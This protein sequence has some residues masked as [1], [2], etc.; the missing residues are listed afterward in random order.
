MRRFS[1]GLIAAAALIATSASPA[2]AAVTI[3]QT[4]TPTGACTSNTFFQ[5]A[6]LAQKYFA[7]SSGVITSWAFQADSSPPQPLKFKVGRPA[8]G[9]SYTVVGT[10]AGVSPTPGVLNTFET[11]IP[12]QAG[13]QIGFF[14]GTSG[15][16]AA[17]APAGNGIAFFGADLSPGDP[18]TTF[19]TQDQRLLDVSAK[20]E[21]DAD[22]DGFGDETQDKCVGSAGSFNGCPSTVSIDSAKQQGKKPR[23]TVTATVPGAGMLQ[24]GAANDASLAS[25]SASTNLKPVTQTISSTAKKQITLTLKLT[26]PA[27]KKLANKGK[28]KTRVKVVYTPTGGPA[29]SQSAKVKLKD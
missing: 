7:P 8:G 22:N 28:L 9:N 2:G 23:I 13:D 19:T 10:S 6:S 20:L 27:K 1:V 5:Q 11:R 14:A 16:C 18:T 24:A 17:T 3:G 26:K 15:G 12:V 4:L 29:A 21:P 25:A